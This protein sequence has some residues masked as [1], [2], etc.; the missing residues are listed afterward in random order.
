MAREVATSVANNLARE[1]VTNIT[2]ELASR[3]ENSKEESGLKESVSIAQ[4]VASNITALYMK[5]AE[6]MKL[7]EEADK[8]R[9]KDIEAANIKFAA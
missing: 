3:K 4:E 9:G 8:G 7:I 5:Q 1:I 2:K 6:T